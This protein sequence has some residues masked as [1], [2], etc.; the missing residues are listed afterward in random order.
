MSQAQYSYPDDKMYMRPQQLEA[1]QCYSVG[2]ELVA[3]PTNDTPAPICRFSSDFDHNF[4]CIS[5]FPQASFF[6]IP[7]K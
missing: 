5:H 4:E 2:T 3:V 6:N 7:I 1:S